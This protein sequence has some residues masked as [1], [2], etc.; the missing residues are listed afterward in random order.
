M[1]SLDLHD[2]IDRSSY[3]RDLFWR[4]KDKTLNLT[5]GMTILVGCNGA[6]KSTLLSVIQDTA[7]RMKIPVIKYDDRVDGDKRSTQTLD[8]FFFS[9]LFGS[10]GEKIKGHVLSLLRDIG[11]MVAHS[12]SDDILIL[13]DS[14]DSGFSI[15]NIIEFKEQMDSIFELEQE[16]GK[17]LYMIITANQYEFTIYERCIDVGTGKDVIFDSYDEYVSFIL[18]SR[19]ERDKKRRD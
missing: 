15:D 7:D 4:Y 10:E 2:A 6:G 18:R 8:D 12:N 1:L 17:N 19:N 5:P 3:A 13:L 9:Y 16:N 11:S 14:I